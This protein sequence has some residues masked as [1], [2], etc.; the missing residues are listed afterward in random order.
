MQLLATT[1]MC[2]CASRLVIFLFAG[3]GK[4][5]MM[6]ILEGALEATAGDVIKSTKDLKIAVLR[7]E[8]VDELVMDRTL[9]EELLAV[10]EKEHSIA[11]VSCL[12]FRDKFCVQFL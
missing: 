5:S 4:T 2:A 8:F 10:F 6:R 9:K 1:F 11:K 12:D 7:Q 3:S